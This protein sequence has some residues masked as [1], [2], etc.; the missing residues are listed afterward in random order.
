MRLSV[1]AATLETM[2]PATLLQLVHASVDV[3][4]ELLNRKRMRR[5]AQPVHTPAMTAMSSAMP[6]ALR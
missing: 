1:L 4:S 6:A 5:V 3:G 2:L